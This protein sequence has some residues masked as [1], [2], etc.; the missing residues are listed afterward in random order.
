MRPSRTATAFRVSHQSFTGRG[1]GELL[2]GAL[3]PIALATALLRADP[4]VVGRSWLEALDAH[5]ERRVSL[6]LVQ[7]DHIVDLMALGNQRAATTDGWRAALLATLTDGL[8]P[9]R[10]SSTHLSLE[11][12]GGHP[13]SGNT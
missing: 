9:D 8:L 10:P 13:G 4:V 6:A 12:A 2:D 1:G 5:A 11:R 3:H 7:P